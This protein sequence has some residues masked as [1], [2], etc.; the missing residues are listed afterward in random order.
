MDIWTELALCLYYES[1]GL[2]GS[3]ALRL[4]VVR[5]RGCE[6]MRVLE[7]EDV[8]QQDSPICWLPGSILPPADEMAGAFLV[9]F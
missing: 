6:E 8:F 3:C 5:L 1:G 9:G 7:P 4:R 2:E